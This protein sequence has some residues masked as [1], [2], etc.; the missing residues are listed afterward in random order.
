MMAAGNQAGA[1][2]APA[3][4]AAINIGLPDS[5][6]TRLNDRHVVELRA[7]GLTDET[8]RAAGLYSARGDVVSRLLGW[9][10]KAGP[11]S[12]ALVYP[13]RAADGAD[14]GFARVKLDFPRR[15]GRGK[16][17]K[18]ES[19][20]G[21]Q[22]RAYF[23][24]RFAEAFATAET[25]L[26]TEGEKKALAASQA[27]FCCI[28]LV[29]VW[30]F[31]KKRLRD[32][33]GKVFGARQLIAE[34]AGLNWRGKSAVI[35]FDSDV[36]DRI[37]LQ[38]AEFRLA[39]LLAQKG[40]VVRVARLP[41]LSESKT[42]LDDYLVHHGSQGAAMLRSLLASAAEAELPTIDGPMDVAKILIDEAFVGATG[43]HLRYWREDFW[44][45]RRRCYRQI[46]SAELAAR[47]LRWMD[48]RGFPATPRFAADVVKCLAALCLVPFEADMPC[49]LDGVRQGEGWIVF[50]NGLFR[51]GEPT[52]IETA[53]H[54]ARYFTPWALDYPF[55]AKADCPTWLAFLEDV[56]DGDPERID[57]LQRWF[58]LLLTPDTSFQKLLLLIGPPRAGKGT[59]VRVIGAL[60]G[61][62]NYASPTLSSLATRFGLA[63]L[64]TKS[65]AL[66]PDAHIGK[67]ADG[68]RVAEA[69][70]SI[71][72]EDP[73]DIDRKYRE[74]LSSVRL[75]TRF[76]VSCNELAHFTDPSGALA[77]RLSVIPF[78][79]SYVGREDRTLE[80]RL[81]A[82][83]SGIANWAIV[84]LAR[85]RTEGR[86]NVPAKSQAIHDNFKRLSSP[87]AAFAEDCLEFHPEFSESTTGVFAAWIGW[88]RANGHE[89]GSLSRLGERLRSVSPDITRTRNRDQE[90]DRHYVY[91]G[92]RLTPLGLGYV[93]DGQR[94]LA[95]KG[96]PP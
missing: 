93:D 36:A 81:R 20:C 53:S 62:D 76:V 1:D 41:P 74:P 16:P 54:T 63:P 75:P 64:L 46:A 77:A 31:Q 58:G 67:H 39:E 83:R 65:V 85:L 82:E 59:I 24:P 19:P 88:C 55:D 80:R 15:A 27:G 66:I 10:S 68:V 26:I 22:N 25:T 23:P 52:R 73:Q 72:G 71:V 29:G 45:F 40:A 92:L 79:N 56:L 37:D 43:L 18:Y 51:I 6:A 89:P 3:G 28:G 9:R 11:W 33:R 96:G 4:A 7:S 5:L 95:G 57:L 34:L 30:G 12:A 84:G 38:L 91:V 8:I 17:V 48:Q 13:Y 2:A 32:D 86:L 69:L 94:T 21:R 49:W 90:G 61:S 70:K 35:V 14:A 50:E 42:G 47:V 44:Q 87:V 78:F 60:I